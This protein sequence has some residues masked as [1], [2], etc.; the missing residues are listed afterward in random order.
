MK[1]PLLPDP[2]PRPSLSLRVVLAL[3]T[4][5]GIVYVLLLAVILWTTMGAGSRDVHDEAATALKEFELL[6]QSGRAFDSIIVLSRIHLERGEVEGAA[7]RL[8]FFVRNLPSPAAMGT[9]A[10]LQDLPPEMILDLSRAVEMDSRIRD[11]LQETAARAVLG[12]PDSA[13]RSLARVDSLN[14]V[15]SA[16]LVQAQQAG[17][18]DL[19]QRERA[20]ADTHRRGLR[21]AGM[22]SVMGAFLILFAGYTIGRR[23]YQPLAE[24]DDA[25][26]RVADGE[27][28][29]ELPVVSTDEIGR[30]AHHFNRMTEVLRAVVEEERD[31]VRRMTRAFM[32]SSFDAVITTDLKGVVTEWNQVA[33]AMFGWNRT[34]VLGRNLNELIVP[35]AARANSED[36]WRLLR[37]DAAAWTG[38]RRDFPAVTR[39]GKALEVEVAL[40]PVA[41]GGRLERVTAFVRDQTE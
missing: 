41:E 28:D 39:T 2:P 14:A 8:N 38:V 27:L 15:F 21:L 12:Q 11:Q 7:E 5:G 33:E 17:I 13:L 32:S 19:V 35:E 18:V 30:L 31:A 26:T 40:V 6:D 25:L 29:L 22:A 10:A 23:L 4:A 24:L 9:L 36:P 16:H 34:D 37:E 1:T 3:L 20:L